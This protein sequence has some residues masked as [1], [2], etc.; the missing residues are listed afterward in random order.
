MGAVPLCLVTAHV[1]QGHE[2]RLGVSIAPTPALQKHGC[3][4]PR[5]CEPSGAQRRPSRQLHR[6]GIGEL[7][8]RGWEGE[9]EREEWEGRD[10]SG[11]TQENSWTAGNEP[12]P[13]EQLVMGSA[14]CVHQLVPWVHRQLPSTLQL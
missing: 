10:G 6:A 14:N 13:P 11:Q 9:E 1:L 12:R 3:A 4:G 5:P 2:S 7:R 8:G